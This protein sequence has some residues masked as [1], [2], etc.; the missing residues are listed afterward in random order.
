MRPLSRAGFSALC[1]G[2]YDDVRLR[3]AGRASVRRD[4][5]VR[6]LRDEAAGKVFWRGLC[7][8]AVL[9]ASV[10]RLLSER[11]VWRNARALM[12]AGCRS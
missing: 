7:A 9:P 8:R 1:L 12:R 2:E 10:L 5:V 11:M 4:E 6:F 3:F